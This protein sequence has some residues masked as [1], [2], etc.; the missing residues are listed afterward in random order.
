MKTVHILMLLLALLLLGCQKTTA[1][2]DRPADK[3]A[4]ISLETGVVREILTPEVAPGETVTINLHVKLEPGQTYYLFDEAVPED[5]EILGESDGKNHIKQIEF[6]DAKS[7]VYTYNVKA[8]MTPGSYIFMGEYAVDTEEISQIK[9]ASAIIV[10]GSA[11]QASSGITRT[12]EKS[13]VSPGETIMVKI[14]ITLAP[15]Q[16]Y[17]LFDEAV[18]ESFEIIGESDGKNHI[19]QI[20]FQNAKSKVYEYSV[21]APAAPGTYVFSGEY[22][23][24]GTDLLAIGGETQLIVR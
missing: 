19:K 14:H 20:E 16:S 1:P 7:T 11:A 5:F 13:A 9:G 15:G 6:Q 10:T 12:F 23:M 3:P 21:K 17:Y 24:D 2:I 4:D 8:P 22:G 18:P